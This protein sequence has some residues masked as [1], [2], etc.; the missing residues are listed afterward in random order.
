MASQVAPVV[1]NLP[2]KAR[3]IRDTGS[4]PEL[5]RS[6]GRGHG[7]PL[8]SGESHGQ[9]S[10]AGYSPWSHKGLDTTEAN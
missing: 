10:L 3:D 4:T 8:L 2:A 9:R 7:N 1:K 6:P 5:G